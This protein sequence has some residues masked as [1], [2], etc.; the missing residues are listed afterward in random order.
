MRAAV[1]TKQ[2]EPVAENVRLIDDHPDPA[3]GSGQV[4]VRTIATGLNHLDLWVGRGVPGMEL[5]YPHIS[6]SDACGVVES[7]GD[8]VDPDWLG[9]R[10]VFNAAMP[11]I[12]HNHPDIAPVMTDIRMIGEHEHGCMAERF[13]CPAENILHISGSCDP[14]EAAAFGLTHLTAW[15][16]LVSQAGLVPGQSVL[17]TGIGGGVALACLNI[18]RHLGCETIVTSRHQWKLDRALEL[19]ADHAVLDDGEDWSNRVRAI[20]HKRGVDICADS[21][22]RAVHPSCIKSLAHGGTFVTCGCTSG[23]IAE[24]NLARMF[25]L[26]QRII[27]ST[28]GDMLEYR[29]VVAIFETG[30]MRPVID[31]VHNAA[32]VAN[33]YARLESGEQLGKIVV[34][35]EVES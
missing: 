30:R 18:C 33:A 5:D 7:V 12:H 23:P 25:W 8:E 21:I 28:M 9:K 15:R 20:T 11:V 26:Q 22:G 35:W 24:T 13:T 14:I 6:G 16:M 2:G 10:V 17:V 27:G 31:S 3:P 32:D 34:R 4:L 19:G 29:K 1:I